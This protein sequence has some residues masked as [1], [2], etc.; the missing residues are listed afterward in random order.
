MREYDH[1]RI[2]L[3]PGLTKLALRGVLSHHEH[4]PFG[5]RHTRWRR[6]WGPALRH[7]WE[8]WFPTIRTLGAARPLSR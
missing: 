7:L 2:T 5:D 3:D 6:A 8:T 4:Y 1:R